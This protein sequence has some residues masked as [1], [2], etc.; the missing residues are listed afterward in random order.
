MSTEQKARLAD[1]R[2]KALDA[3]EAIAAILRQMKG[4]K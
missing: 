4:G 3:S 1:A 2:Q